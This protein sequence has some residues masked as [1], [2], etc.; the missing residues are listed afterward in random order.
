MKESLPKERRGQGEG[1][2]KPLERSI[3]PLRQ[4]EAAKGPAKKIFKLGNAKAGTP[5]TPVK[6]TAGIR[7]RPI[8]QLKIWGERT[9]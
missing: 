4:R 9:K 2:C 1:V 8:E 7:G 6:M 5:K 3:F